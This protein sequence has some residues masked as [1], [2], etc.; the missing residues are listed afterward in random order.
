MN[1]PTVESLSSHNTVGISKSLYICFILSF[2]DC[3]DGPYVPSIFKGRPAIIPLILFSNIISLNLETNESSILFDG[4]EISESYEGNFDGMTVHSSGNIFTS[5][6]GG[7]LV[8]S[9]E[10][11]LMAKIDFG[12][13]TNAT[14]DDDESYLYVTGFVNNPK[15]FRIKLK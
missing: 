14:F 3:A 13:L 7:L 6:P 10:G 15:V 9:P 12:H 2:T 8:I 11:D 4:K 5:G 1:E